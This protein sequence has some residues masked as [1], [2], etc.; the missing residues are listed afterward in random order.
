MLAKLEVLRDSNVRDSLDWL[1]IPDVWSDPGFA[2]PGAVPG[3]IMRDRIITEWF[4]YVPDG[5]GG[6][7]KPN[8]PMSTTGY[9]I[10][11]R[12]DVH[13]IVRRALMWAMEVSLA[14]RGEAPEEIGRAPWPI[15]LFWKCPAPWFEAWVVSRR[16][17]ESVAE[18]EDR[19]LVTVVL[20]SP[21]HRGAI[22][23]DSPIATSEV[24]SPPGSPH[25]VPSTQD[26]Y[27]LLDGIHP[28]P[29]RPRVNA[30]NRQN[31]TWVVSQRQHQIA[32][33]VPDGPQ[34]L[35]LAIIDRARQENTI[36]PWP[37]AEWAIP[38]FAVWEGT[39]EVVVVAPSMPA[40]GVKHDGEV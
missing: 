16:N 5:L 18:G 31:A 25:P 23:A 4:G 1:D 40:G 39:G 33:V 14:T 11:Y 24:A 32:G 15:E 37:F 2:K 38:Q 34:T 17:P 10:G 26:D 27:E 12:G 22:V 30:L 28:R 13:Q 8:P 29:G 21:S 20:V 9:W 36:G 3:P 7:E 6:W 35:S 19:G